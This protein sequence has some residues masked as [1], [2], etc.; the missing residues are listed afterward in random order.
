MLLALKLTNVVFVAIISVKM[1]TIVGILAFI[2]RINSMLELRMKV[3][4]EKRFYNPNASLIF[5]RMLKFCMYM[6]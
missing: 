5:S 6:F 2:S 1:P 3:E 4:N